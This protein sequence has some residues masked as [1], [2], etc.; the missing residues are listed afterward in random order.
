[1]IMLDGGQYVDTTY[2]TLHFLVPKTLR[3]APAPVAIHYYLLFAS[4][5]RRGRHAHCVHAAA[6]PARAGPPTCAHARGGGVETAR[7]RE[8]V[9]VSGEPRLR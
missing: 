1:M 7:A 6:V 8:G 5:P 3:A 4:G 2:M 9:Q